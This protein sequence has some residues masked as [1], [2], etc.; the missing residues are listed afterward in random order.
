M[1]IDVQTG[2]QI[3]VCFK[4]LTKSDITRYGLTT[5][6]KWFDWKK[7]INDGNKRVF[8]IFTFGNNV[9]EIQKY[10]F[11]FKNRKWINTFLF[12]YGNYSS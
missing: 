8:G 4:E 6:N 2:K 9:K 5:R 11:L 7:E 10:N 3:D 1:I 12:T